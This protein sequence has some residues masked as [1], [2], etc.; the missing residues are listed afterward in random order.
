MRWLCS[1]AFVSFAVLKELHHLLT[2]KCVTECDV[3]AFIMRFPP[4][5]VDVLNRHLGDRINSSCDRL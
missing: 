5:A 3:I 4:I 1:I 2:V